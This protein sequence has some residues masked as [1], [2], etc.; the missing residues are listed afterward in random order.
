M[1]QSVS[2]L[3]L[4]VA[5]F[6]VI[7]YKLIKLPTSIGLMI[8]GI[9]MAVGISII[10]LVSNET[11]N[12]LCTVVLNADF[13]NL[14]F[15]GLLSF[16]LFAG[17]IHV[18][19][20][21]L[22]KQKRFVL[23][24]A[25]L[26]V[27]IST[28]I[29][30]LLFYYTSHLLQMPVNFIICLLFGALISPTDPV[31]ALAILSKSGVSD[32]IKMKIEGESLFNVGIGVIVFSGILMW[33]NSIGSVH[34][35]DLT[36]EIFFLFLEEVI[37]GL[38]FGF[39]LG[40]SGYRLIKWSS[41]NDELQIILSLSIAASGY[42]IAQI[43]GV[44]GPLAMVVAGIIVGNKLHVNSNK[45]KL[46]FFNKFWKVLDETLNGILFLMIGLSLHLITFELNYLILSTVVIVLVLI[47]RY[48]SVL[49]PYSFLK[50]GE[51][52]KGVIKLLTW[53]GLR[54]GISLGLA[55]SLP[56]N[57]SKELIIFITFVVVAFSIIIQGLTI[58]K[59]SNRLNR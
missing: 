44:S 41:D 55:M 12:V 26:S 46:T 38:A 53:G 14:L 22:I 9:A 8:L 2:I 10:K 7:N 18:D 40:Y 30:G 52:D 32:K 28:F 49:I 42:A 27:L 34:T 45:N 21:L 48:I 56:E 11:Y 6:S 58:G 29:I 31:A 23:S 17:A 54:G 5:L 43:I 15:D 39:V 20:S 24:F 4:I 47:S 1:F 16:L 57:E 25:T 35:T 33:F 59:L 3:L 13:K 51:Q 37:G 19:Y 50:K 36:S